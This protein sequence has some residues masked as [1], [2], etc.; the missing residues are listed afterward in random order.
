MAVMVEFT[1]VNINKTRKMIVSSA[2]FPH[3]EEGSLPPEPVNR[4]VKHCQKMR[5]P[6]ILECDAN[7]HHTI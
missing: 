4:L 3:E 1:R 5:L 6:L 2:N 7:A